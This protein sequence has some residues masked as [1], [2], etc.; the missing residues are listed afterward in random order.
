MVWPH[1]EILW[2]GEDIS[3]SDNER[4]KKE[5]S[6]KEMRRQSRKTTSQ[7]RHECALEIP[8]GL[9]KTWTSVVET[10]CVV[11]KRLWK[12]RNGDDMS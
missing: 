8:L 7:T 9:R 10:A 12:L 3:A 6:D 11:P 5:K 4:I 2:H 1:L